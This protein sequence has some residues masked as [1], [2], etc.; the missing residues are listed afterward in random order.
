MIGRDVI[1]VAVGD[2]AAPSL[3]A[4]AG[5]LSPDLDAAVI[6]AAEWTTMRLDGMARVLCGFSGLPVMVAKEGDPV[7]PGHFYVG[8]NTRMVV[9]QPGRIALDPRPCDGKSGGVGE[10]L[11]ASASDSYGP[12][13]IAIV[14]GRGGAVADETLRRV[15]LRGGITIEEQQPDVLAPGHHDE[16]RHYRLPVEDMSHVLHDFA[17]VPAA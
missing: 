12:R 15:R 6:A 10:R 4:F 8:P 11:I 2:Q 16:A 7:V 17:G 5:I 14:L 1:V 13:V 9:V 3:C